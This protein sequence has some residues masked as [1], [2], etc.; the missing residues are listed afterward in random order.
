ML[1]GN[2]EKRKNKRLK[3]RSEFRSFHLTGQSLEWWWTGGT[4]RGDGGWGEGEVVY[5][6][7]FDDE[8]DRDGNDVASSIMSW[9]GND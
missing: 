1:K 6:F 9:A 2:S 8:K 4:G 7:A 5:A 3:H